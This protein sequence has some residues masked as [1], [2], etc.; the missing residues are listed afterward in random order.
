MALSYEF[1][2]GS[3]RAKEISLFTNSDFE[4]L[5]ACKSTDELCRVLNDKGYGNGKSIDDIINNHMEKTWS[6]LKSITPDF[7][8]FSPFIIQNDIHNLKVVLKVT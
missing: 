8:I 4:Q 1:S 6:Y 2:I 5:I 7:E 3:V